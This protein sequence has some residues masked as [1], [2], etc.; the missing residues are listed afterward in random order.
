MGRDHIAGIACMPGPQDDPVFSGAPNC[1]HVGKDPMEQM[2]IFGPPQLLLAG[3]QLEPA[4][5]AQRGGQSRAREPQPARSGREVR[6]LV[7]L[8]PGGRVILTPAVVTSGTG[9]KLLA[10]PYLVAEIRGRLPK[11][12]RFVGR[13]DR[14]ARRSPR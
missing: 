12:E 9:A 7:T 5:A 14:A 6:C 3:V 13:K 11:P 10:K 2:A 4:R 1:R 8:A